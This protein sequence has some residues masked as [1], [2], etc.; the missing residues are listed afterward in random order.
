MTYIATNEH[1]IMVYQCEMH[2]VWHLGPGGVYDPKKL[3]PSLNCP[4]CSRPNQLV[5]IDTLKHGIHT[6]T[7]EVHG[8]WHLGPSG[9]YD[10]NDPPAEVRALLREGG[11]L[12]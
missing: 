7:C 4:R 10:P 12:E 9:L 1:A 11:L 8:D 6:Y 3:R 2:G 5:Y